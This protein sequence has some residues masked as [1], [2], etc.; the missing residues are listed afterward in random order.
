M[1]KEFRS[2]YLH[3]DADDVQLTPL[4]RRFCW[5]NIRRFFPPTSYFENYLRIF[6]TESTSSSLTRFHCAG[7]SSSD[8]VAKFQLQA[9]NAQ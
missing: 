6:G 7:S 1:M 2:V 8:P 5:R 4:R 3:R 9:E